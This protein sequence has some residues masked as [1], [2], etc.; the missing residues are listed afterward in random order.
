MVW[1]R[2][3]YRVAIAVSFNTKACVRVVEGRRCELTEGRVLRIYM[4]RS[5]I[6]SW[7]DYFVVIPA[8][9]ERIA[10]ITEYY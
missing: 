10:L 2:P 7:Y 3:R 8:R 5:Y 4:T 1:M 9:E 6:H